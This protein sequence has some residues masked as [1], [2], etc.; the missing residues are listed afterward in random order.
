M[1][2]TVT[3]DPSVRSGAW[4]PASR[5]RSSRLPSSTH[6][7]RTL[8][9]SPGSAMIVHVPGLDNA[10][11]FARTHSVGL[12]NM[13]ASFAKNQPIVKAVAQLWA[14]VA[15]GIRHKFRVELTTF[16]WE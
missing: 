16:P 11:A 1:P 6:A 12:L 13:K 8:V 5:T 9:F 3:G 4:M 15:Y 10:K 14:H 7:S 2:T